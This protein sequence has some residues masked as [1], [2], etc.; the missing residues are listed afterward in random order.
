MKLIDLTLTPTG[1]IAEHF[2][3]NGTPD[4]DMMGLFGTHRIPTAFTAQAEANV[5]LETIQRRNPASIVSLNPIRHI[6]VPT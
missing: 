1:W 3:E 5:V 6:H 2:E 4:A